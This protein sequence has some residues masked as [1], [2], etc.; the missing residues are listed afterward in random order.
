MFTKLRIVLGTATL[1]AAALIGLSACAP[2]VTNAISPEEVAMT[3]LGYQQADV[4]PAA[5][6]SPSA[7][8]GTKAGRGRPVL[9]RMLRGKVVHGEVV[10]STKNGDK[11]IDVQRGAVTAVNTTSLTVKSADGF[12]L[13]WSLGTS[14][15]VVEK[16]TKV[17]I[18]NVTVGEEVGVAGTRSGSTVTA[19]LI[20]IPKGK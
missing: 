1:A 11:T 5:A 8:T 7:A 14:V 13:T 4:T 20:L 3:A 15:R 19:A 12:T 10:V 16:G 6:P 2:G 18:S 9:R 17:Q